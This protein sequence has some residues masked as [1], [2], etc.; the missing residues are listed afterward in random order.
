MWGFLHVPEKGSIQDHSAKA[1]W[2]SIRIWVSGSNGAENRFKGYEGSKA[3]QK[4][5]LSSSFE[6]YHEPVHPPR[7]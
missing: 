1:V 7:K 6:A 3:D 2:V 5:P 4:I